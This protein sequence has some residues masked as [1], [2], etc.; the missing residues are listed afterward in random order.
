MQIHIPKL[1]NLVANLL[2][3][4]LRRFKEK[5]LK[6]FLGEDEKGCEGPE[7]G[8]KKKKKKRHL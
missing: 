1:N 2:Q 8:R 4:R 3:S 6:H 7:K 5:I